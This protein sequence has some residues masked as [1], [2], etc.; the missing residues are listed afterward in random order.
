MKFQK[1]FGEGKKFSGSTTVF[2]PKYVLF[3]YVDFV[4]ESAYG[5]YFR[6]IKIKH[7][8]FHVYHKK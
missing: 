6:E 2:H 4:L 1:R 8:P 5:S 3:R 7:I